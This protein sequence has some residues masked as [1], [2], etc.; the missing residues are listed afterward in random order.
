MIT[1][2]TIALLAALWVLA[3]RHGYDSREGLR[4]KEQDLASYG[5]TW[6]ELADPHGHVLMARERQ[7]ELRATPA[8]L[9]SGG[10]RPAPWRAGLA[11]CLRALADRLEPEGPARRAHA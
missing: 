4:S 9:P 10:T 5:V 6:L 1:V 2:F 3:L 8:T 11:R 7:A